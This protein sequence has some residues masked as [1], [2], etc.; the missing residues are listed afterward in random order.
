M[1]GVVLVKNSKVW[2]NVRESFWFLP[3]VYGLSAIMLVF[4]TN[5]L[6]AWLVSSFKDNIPKQIIT[7]KDTAKKLYAT[8]VTAIL[9][10]TTI[11]FS[12]IMV[13]LTTYASQFSPRVLQDFMK[14]RVTQHVLGI[15]CSGFLFALLLLL[16]IDYGKPLLGPASMVV[17]AILNL[18]AFVYFI[19][20]T[21]RWLQVNRLVGM[22]EEKGTKA[23]KEMTKEKQTYYEYSSWNKDEIN[24]YR[25]QAKSV[26]TAKRSGYIQSINWSGMI[27]CA[28]KHDVAV[29][30]HVQVG[31]F[32]T[33]DLPIM[34]V[35]ATEQ[36]EAV[37]QLRSFLIVGKERTDVQD[38][39]FTIQKIG[40]IAL[41]AISP[42][43]NDP[44]TA[45][46]CINRIGGLL[47]ELGDSQKETPYL[48]DDQ[49]NL[50]VIHKTKSFEEYLYKS[51]YQIRH[52][53]QN[54]ISVIYGI[55]EV[56]Y[57]IARSSDPVIKD[58]IWSFH[59][60]ILDVVDWNHLSNLDREH[61]N[62]I[63]IKLKECCA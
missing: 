31:S 25:N 42:S 60:Y 29:D 34:N 26:L 11:S 54:D 62:E 19:H 43:T 22:I 41:R 56:L 5:I 13:V 51:F 35:Y 53:G 49:N 2:I 38:V 27:E 63:Y 23:I 36:T 58:K 39:E 21:A 48:A 32:I 33:H 40:E 15:Y 6:D 55:L 50:R 30:L 17:I 3:A 8:L 37:E 1:K 18:G 24:Q 10:M 45:V 52:Y 46:N 61:L 47:I 16:L 59:F 20:H 7:G 9:T 4:L 14:S 12:V 28:K 44:H 57:K